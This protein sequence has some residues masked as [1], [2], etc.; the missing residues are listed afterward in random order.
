MTAPRVLVADDNPDNLELM[1]ILLTA[2]GYAPAL[3]SDGAEA[4]ESAADDPPELILMDL[5]M[6]NVDGYAAAAAIRQ[7][8][9]GRCAPIVAVTALAMVGD[10][11]DV[12]AA[13]F[14]GYIAKPIV[15]ATFLA[16]VE[17]FIAP[18]RRASRAPS[19]CS[20]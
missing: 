19:R 2:S 14:D 18:E 9:G 17:E 4:I 7:Q 6:P 5:Q 20:P 8:S 15:P 3:A 16:Q 10:R 12:L 1:R 11:D 13:G